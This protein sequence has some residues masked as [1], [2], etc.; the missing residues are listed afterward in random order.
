[1]FLKKEDLLYRIRTLEIA[2]KDKNDRIDNLKWNIKTLER[3]MKAVKSALENLGVHLVW[4]DEEPH[5]EVMS[6]K[7]YDKYLKNIEVK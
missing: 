5:Y 7:E 4:I 6:D 1:M 3:E 2:D